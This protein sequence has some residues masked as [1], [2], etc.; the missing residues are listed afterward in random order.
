MGFAQEPQ[1]I[2][3]FS[4]DEVVV[5][6]ALANLLSINCN[7]YSTQNSYVN[8]LY[9]YS[10]SCDQPQQLT[11]KVADQTEVEGSAEQEFYST[12]ATADND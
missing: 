12:P 2:A 5:V 10:H 7:G 11:L 4:R 3:S 6:L 1:L 9:F 8:F